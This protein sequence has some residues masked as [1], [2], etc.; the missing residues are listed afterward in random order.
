MKKLKPNEHLY[1]LS[2]YDRDPMMNRM[3]QVIDT[4]KSVGKDFYPRRRYPDYIDYSAVLTD[5]TATYL[6]LAFGDVIGMNRPI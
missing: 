1:Y 4:M 5:D 2:V 6:L 3:Q